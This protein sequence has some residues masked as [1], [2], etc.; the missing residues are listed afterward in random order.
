M[1]DE[2]K[3]YKKEEQE[4]SFLKKFILS[5]VINSLLVIVIFL[6]SLIYIRQSDVNKNKFKN[7]VYNNSLS[8]AHIYNL[9]NK[10]LGDVIPFKNIKEDTT[11]LVSKEKLNFSEVKKEN[12]GY[13]L[14]VS[15]NYLVPVIKS[16]I[17]IEKKKDKKYGNI[18]KIQDKNEVV[19][20]YGMISDINVKLY[21]YVKEGEVIGN[22]NKKIYIQIKKKDKYI[23]YDKYL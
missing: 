22:A 23:S 11:K 18:I 10:Y 6:I 20:T 7:I 5:N 19:I 12:N 16:G 15:D 8:F 1:K 2:F 3:F 13:I 21:D 17:I 4:E 9:Y 14:T